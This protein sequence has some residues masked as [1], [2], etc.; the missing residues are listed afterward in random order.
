MGRSWMQHLLWSGWGDPECS[1]CRIHFL[2]GRGMDFFVSIFSVTGYHVAAGQTGTAVVLDAW[3][4]P[5]GSSWKTEKRHR[6][7][8][9][10]PSV[11]KGHLLLL[12]P[13]QR[14]HETKALSW[15]C[16]WDSKKSTSGFIMKSD[17]RKKVCQDLVSTQ[18]HHHSCCPR[19]FSFLF[20][21][22]VNYGTFSS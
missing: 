17:R 13:S 22:L 6:Q 11:R 16:N 14:L 10:L 4:A 2:L 1:S 8:D 3:S 5:S 7:R 15:R 18:S 21:S 9:I 12:L 19:L 20:F